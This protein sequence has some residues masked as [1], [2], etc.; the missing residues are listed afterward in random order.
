MYVCVCV[1][2]FP[3][4][5]LYIYIM[6]RVVRIE[7]ETKENMWQPINKSTK[8]HTYRCIYRERAIYKYIVFRL[9]GAFLSGRERDATKPPC[10]WVLI[11]V[12]R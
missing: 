6:C 4:Y 9:G 3:I 7:R 8:T 11:E 1:C 2:V 12:R 10:L 5:I